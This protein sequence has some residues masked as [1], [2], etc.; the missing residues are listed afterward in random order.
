[1]AK[2]QF[3]LIIDSE[4]TIT[5][6]VYDFGAVVC[7]RKG[8]IHASC[9]V[10]VKE[11]LTT[12]LF[13]DPNVTGL[14][15]K[16]AAVERAAKYAEMINQGS[17]MVA[18]V[19]AINR[20]LEKVSGKYAPILTA[21]NLAFDSGKCRNT[22]ID[23]TMFPQSFCLWHLAAEMICTTKAYKQFAL[24]NHYFGN[25]TAYGN[26]TVKT[27][28]ECVA[29]FVTGNDVLE[30]HTAIEDAQFFELPILCKLVNRKGWKDH[31][32]KA[33]NW[34]NYQVRDSFIAK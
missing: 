23:L 11:E 29:H 2:K 22:G 17:R 1:M 10:I 25:R 31:M 20:W 33:Y 27:N 9:A 8:V 5:D 24:Q 30:P 13:Y 3:F 7:D 16:A 14:W 32:H 19:A 12:E 18:S 34:R 6:K 21:Y 15:G 26:M 28:A 4:T